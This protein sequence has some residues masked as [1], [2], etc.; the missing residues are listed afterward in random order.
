MPVRQARLLG[1]LRLGERARPPVAREAAHA[2][3]LPD[4]VALAG[5]DPDAVRGEHVTAAAAAGDAGAR[6][7]LEEL[8]WWLAL[9][10]SNMALALDS[11]VMVVGGGLVEAIGLVLERV[12]ADFD[13]LLEGRAYRPAV[14]IVPAALGERAGAIGAA[15]VAREGG[16]G[17][18]GEP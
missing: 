4:V 2:G 17:R 6:S 7:V 16:R 8:A 18:P 5:G 12:R 13:D 14:T 1:A 15:L 10:L 9:G 3:R 11:S